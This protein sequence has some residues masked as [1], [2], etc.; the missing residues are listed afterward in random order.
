MRS[1]RSLLHLHQAR[2]QF[3]IA[4]SSRKPGF[5]GGGSQAL[6]PEPAPD[7]E[8]LVDPCS[9]VATPPRSV[10][11]VRV[12]APGLWGAPCSYKVG[13]A[14]CRG[15]CRRLHAQRPVAVQSNRVVTANIIG[16]QRLT[17]GD[18]DDDVHAA[19]TL[20]VATCSSCPTPAT[21]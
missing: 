3:L 20:P 14:M 12:G 7:G 6:T 5:D 18:M 15:R 4:A 13:V 9:T 2:Q 17:H 11:R 16:D 19:M 1:V 10:L 21:C 8:D